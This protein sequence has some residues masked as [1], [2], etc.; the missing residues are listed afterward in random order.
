MTKKSVSMSGNEEDSIVIG[1]VVQ[2]GGN[3]VMSNE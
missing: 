2:T 1:R 3:V